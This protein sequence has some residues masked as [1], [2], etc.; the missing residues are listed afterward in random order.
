[1]KPYWKAVRIENSVRAGTPDVYFTMKDN[2][3]MGW[4]ELKYEPHWPAKDKTPLKINHFTPEQRLFLTIHGRIGANIWLFLQVNQDYFLLSWDV[5]I[6][7]GELTR[8]NLI[9]EGY[10]WPNK[11]VFPELKKVLKK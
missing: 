4:M 2:G 3:R 1:M 6:K 10:H 5:A 7:I 11:L 9:Q 8:S